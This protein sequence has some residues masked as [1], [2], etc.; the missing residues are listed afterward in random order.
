M[1]LATIWQLGNQLP[2][3]VASR[4][5]AHERAMEHAQNAGHPRLAIGECD[6]WSAKAAC[7][8]G[9]TTCQEVFEQRR[10]TTC[11]RV[12]RFACWGRV[13]TEEQQD[14]PCPCRGSC[15]TAG[16]VLPAV[17]S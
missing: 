12:V 10:L 14:R 6:Y 2:I 5:R 15:A 3:E 4:K 17:R 11:R 13:S 8:R 1:L 9:E 7:P 16:P